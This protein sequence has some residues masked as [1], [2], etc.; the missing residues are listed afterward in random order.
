MNLQHE[1]IAALC[2]S[3]G[4]PFVAQSYGAATQKAAKQEMAYSDFLEGLLKE[5]AAGR[6]VRKQSTLTRLA[7]FPVVK[8]LDDFDYDFAKGV[9]RSQIEEL[10]GLGFVERHE[11]VVLIGPSGV[12]KTHLAMALG[13]RA[14]QAGI[15][16]RFMT[17][18]DLLLTLTTAHVQNNLKTVMH[19]AIKAYRLLIIDEIGYLPMNREQANLFFQVIAAMYERGSLIV[20]SNLPFGQ[21]D[22]TFAQDAT[23]TAALLD[24]LLHHAHIV[25]VAG[26]SYRLK[27]QR[28]AGMIRASGSEEMA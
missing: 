17:A 9:K 19:R 18:A 25:P 22:T 20:T 27:H 16:T 15:K 4:L 10:A 6:N 14:T 28:Q 26:E 8:T 23:L 13:Y 11:N 2:E 24:R 3:L 7:G 12:G 1:R 21:W 5:E